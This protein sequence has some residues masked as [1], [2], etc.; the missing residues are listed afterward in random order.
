MGDKLTRFRE[1]FVQFWTRPRKRNE[2]AAWL[3]AASGV[4]IKGLDSVIRIQG[5]WT[6]LETV[7]ETAV[8]SF[9]LEWGWV[10]VTVLGFLW[11]GLLQRSTKG[12]TYQFHKLRKRLNLVPVRKTQQYN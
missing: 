7:G 11:L 6:L 9:L 8:V 3:T 5:V 12:R 1:T 4:F 10:V 2:I